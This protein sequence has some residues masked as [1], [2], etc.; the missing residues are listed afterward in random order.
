MLVGNKA[1]L[2]HLRAITT[3]DAKAFAERE[4]FFFMEASAR[5]ALNVE[6]AFTQLLTQIYRKA[7]L[8]GEIASSTFADDDYDYMYKVVLIG[9]SGV[10]KSNLLSRFSKNEFSLESKST[11][12]VEFATRSINVDDMIIKGQMWDTNGQE[13]YRA[14]P[15][16]YYR[17]A[18]GAIIVYDITRNVTY[19]NV[20]RW[21]KEFRAYTDPG[22]VVMLVGNKADLGYLRAITTNDAKAFAERENILFMEASAQDALNVTHAFTELLTQIHIKAQQGPY[23][24]HLP[25]PMKTTNRKESCATCTSSSPPQPERGQSRRR[26]K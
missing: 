6:N 14:I 2:G 17:G 3:D 7:L 16:S 23:P 18:V 8:E 13:R 20:E 21:L 1:D 26:D 19:E 12:G 25:T 22:I 4:N 15:S 9:D 24:R 10:G 11:I 5:D